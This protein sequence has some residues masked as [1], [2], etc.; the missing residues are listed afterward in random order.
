[1]IG[2]KNAV[3]ITGASGY[4][5]S[6]LVEGLIQSGFDV[7]GV[8]K[9]KGER[10]PE[11]VE[12]AKKNG[13]QNSY[14]H[15]KVD[16]LHKDQTIKLIETLKN[17]CVEVMAIIHLACLADVSQSKK[18]PAKTIGENLLITQNVMLMVERLRPD[19][20]IYANSC[21]ATTD[22]NSE[23][24]N[25]YGYSKALCHDSILN[26]L[27]FSDATYINIILTNPIGCLK[28]IKKDRG[29]PAKIANAITHDG[30]LRLSVGNNKGE[31][32][33]VY[34]RNFV[35]IYEVIGC[36][37]HA[38]TA[39]IYSRDVTIY[40]GSIDKNCSRFPLYAVTQFAEY[41]VFDK[42]VRITYVKPKENEMTDIKVA[43]IEVLLPQDNWYENFLNDIPLSL[44]N[45]KDKNIRKIKEI[46]EN[47]RD[48]LAEP[49]V[50]FELLKRCIL[51]NSDVTT[52]I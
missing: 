23:G 14:T 47:E 34:K 44:L 35:S 15:F 36:F 30:V 37:I 33:E 39:Y 40:C 17:K 11:W 20:V 8:D 27:M 12:I 29:L 28:Y 50:R 16:L 32:D 19:R 48:H 38:L 41:C 49:S 26:N 9:K 3:L 1:M 10:C 21:M 7:I 4:I 24:W 52:Q 6:N 51:V 22:Y 45:F 46:L 13:L 2:I 42:Y 18:N 5:G 43:N 25:A 31:H